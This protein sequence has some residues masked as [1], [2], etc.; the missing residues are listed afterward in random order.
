MS[1]AVSV[2]QVLC[3]QGTGVFLLTS[4]AAWMTTTTIMRYKQDKKESAFLV[5]Q[6]SLDLVSLKENK[7][8]EITVII[9]YQPGEIVFGDGCSKLCRCAGNYTLACVDNSC[10]PTEEC[11]EVN[12]V[13][14]CY[15][16][17]NFLIGDRS[18][19]LCKRLQ[20][21]NPKP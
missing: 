10:A 8:N 18:L 21:R 14:G 20:V 1:A 17:G 19:A 2:D 13:P 11:R 16:Q 9:F 12:G 6:L 15:P 5:L 4:V 7:S 3:C